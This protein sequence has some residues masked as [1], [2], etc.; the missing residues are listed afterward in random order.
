MTC[1]RSSEWTWRRSQGNW[2]LKSPL[3]VTWCPTLYQ[4]ILLSLHRVAQQVIGFDSF[5]S[6]HSQSTTTFQGT[7]YPSFSRSFIHY[8]EVP[9]YCSLK[10]FSHLQP[11]HQCLQ[12]SCSQSDS[13]A[14]HF[15]QRPLN[16]SLKLSWL[17]LFSFISNRQ[18]GVDHLWSLVWRQLL[19]CSYLQNLL[20]NRRDDYELGSLVAFLDPSQDPLSLLEF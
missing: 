8:C 5:G 18:W 6:S 10:N 11:K 2:I 9:D 1:L 17:G 12:L 3:W 14:V 13:L 7:C 4:L 16:Y 20:R 15:P 19:Q